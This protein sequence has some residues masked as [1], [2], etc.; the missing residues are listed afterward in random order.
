PYTF[1]EVR[2]ELSKVLEEDK[3]QKL[4]DGYATKLRDEFYVEERPLQ[5]E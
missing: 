3:L 2:E 4:Y 1:E 5:Q